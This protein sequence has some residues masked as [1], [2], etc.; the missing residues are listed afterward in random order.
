MGFSFVDNTLSR[1]SL[2]HYTH[3]EAPSAALEVGL[4]W[5]YANSH[6]IVNQRTIVHGDVGYN[7]IL[8]DGNKLVALLD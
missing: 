4:E 5:L 6:L 8:F 3:T 2:G 7:N 1:K